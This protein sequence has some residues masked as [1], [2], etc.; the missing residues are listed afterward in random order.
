MRADEEEKFFV[1]EELILWLH[2]AGSWRVGAPRTLPQSIYAWQ[3]T[4]GVWC[5]PGR[6]RD[7]FCIAILPPGTSVIPFYCKGPWLSDRPKTS[8]GPESCRAEPVTHL[9]SAPLVSKA[10][11]LNK[12]AIKMPS[13]FLTVGQASGHQAQCAYFLHMLVKCLF[14]RTEVV[15]KNP[16]KPPSTI[17]RKIYPFQELLPTQG[18][19]RLVSHFPRAKWRLGEL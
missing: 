12:M 5:C 9:G 3:S 18:I 19:W 14:P 17:S 16:W 7:A 1:I 2:E 13:N 10:D 8:R 15:Q 11:G 4:S 6:A